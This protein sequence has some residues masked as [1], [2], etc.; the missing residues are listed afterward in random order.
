[1]NPESVEKGIRGIK[2][3]LAHKNLLKIE[4]FP[5]PETTT[6]PLKL[7]LKSQAKRYYAPTGGMI[8]N[9]VELGSFVKTGETLYQ[10]LSF[11]KTENLPQIVEVK[12]E[13]TGIIFDISTNHTVNQCDYV[14]S[15]L[16]Q[17]ST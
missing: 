8:Q 6:Y 9:R 10:I 3:Y 16:E 5:L 14:L 12:T 17:A 7:S 1:M 13:V 2:N 15:V 11:N 4:N